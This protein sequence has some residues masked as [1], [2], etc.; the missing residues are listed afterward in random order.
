MF[1]FLSYLLVCIAGL[2]IGSF[3][4]AI[5]FRTAH[6]DRIFIKHS[7][8]D[9][10]NNIIPFL[11]LTPIVGILICNGK[12]TKCG[13][14]ISYEY[15][16]W[17]IIHA[18][19]Y[20]INYYIFHNNLYAFIFLCLITSI[21]LLISIVDLKT[22]YVYDIHLVILTMFIMCF[23]YNIQRLN[24]NLFSCVKATIPFIFKYIYEYI[25]HQLTKHKVTIIG[26]GDVKLFSILF[27]LLDFY[28]LAEI[29]G[30]SGLLGTMYGML[31]GRTN[32]YPFVPAI[33]VS[34]YFLFIL[35][36]E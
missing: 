32:H 10:C 18:C 1:I 33:S 4:T 22:M 31:R 26:T 12:C 23:L 30:L 21:L 28:K 14:K 11:Y 36:Y 13:N 27:F 34:T 8:C 2:Y 16:L 29:I 5:S 3:I 7:K 25:R 20:I 9:S 15:T 17:E 24:I 35:S 6:E 19:L